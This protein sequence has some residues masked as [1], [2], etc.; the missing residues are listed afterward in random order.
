MSGAGDEPLPLYGLPDAWPG[1]RRRRKHGPRG[2]D[3]LDVWSGRHSLTG[4]DSA[5][6]VCSQRRAIHEG[7][8]GS[9]RVKGPEDLIRLDAAWAAIVSAH[10]EELEAL[11]TTSGPDA[12]RHRVHELDEAAQRIAHDAAAWQ[13]SQLTIDGRSVE[14]IEMTYNGWWVV[15]HIGIDEV[16][17][18][19]VYGPP[20]A[21]P[22][23]LVLE[24]VSPAAY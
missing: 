13:S 21:R 6:E 4:S 11:R 10:E 5:I 17:D 23:P 2:K 20:G 8:C 3:V 24:S 12:V 1:E 7:L 9:L 16:A 15:L 18:V 14:A 19:Y 22:T